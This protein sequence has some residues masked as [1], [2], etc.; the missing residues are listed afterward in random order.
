MDFLRRFNVGQRLRLLILIFAA[1]FAAYGYWSFR[2]LAEIKVGGPVFQRIAQSQNLVSDVLPPPVY[3]IESYLVA[4]RITAAVDSQ[5]QGQLID[6][7][8]TLHQQ[9][10]QR[11]AF[12]ANAQLK[13]EV[14]EVLLRQAHIPTLAF[15]DVLFQKFLPA[16]YVNDRSAMQSA[17]TSMTASYEAHRAAIDQVVLLAQA[18]ARDDE[19]AAYAQIQQATVLLFGI[20]VVAMALA[21]GL[22]TWIRRSIKRPLSQA[23]DIA[24]QVA[25]GNLSLPPSEPYDDEAGQLLI[26]L[27][28]MSDSLRETMDALSKAEALSRHDKQIA[29]TANQ[30]KSEFLANMSHE[31]RTPMNAVIGMTGLALRTELTPKQRGYLEKA[32]VAARNLMGIINDVLDFSKIEAGKLGF[33]Q[34]DFS[35]DHVLEHLASVTVLKAQE[36]GLELLFDVAKDV[37]PALVG[38]DMRLGQV[39]LNLVNN[40]VKFTPQGEIRVRVN[41]LERDTTTAL[42]RFEVQDTGIGITTAQRARL[43]EAFIQADASTTRQYGGTGLGLSIS[44]KLVEMMGGTIWVE[45]EEGKGSSFIFTASLRL[46]DMFTA[47]SVDADPLLQHLRILVVDDNQSAREIMVGIVESLNLEVQSAADGPSAIQALEAAQQ[48]GRPFHMVMM[49]WQMP[50]MDG[51]QAIRQIRGSEKIAETLATVMVT[52]FSRDDLIEKAE[53]VRLDG[54]LEKP[55][56][57]SAVLDTIARAMG[58]MRHSATQSHQNANNASLTAH[59]RGARVLLV[60]DNEVNQE[61]ASEILRESGVQVTV[62]GD[63][64]QA[65]EQLAKQPFDAVLMD[66]QMPVMDGFEATRRIRSDPG[67]ALLPILAMTANAMAGDREKCLAAGMNDHIAK[68]IEVDALLGTLARWVSQ[69]RASAPEVA[70]AAPSPSAKEAP[71]DLP[72]VD[73]ATALRRLRGNLS[74]YRNLLERFATEFARGDQPLQDALAAEDWTS[75]HRWAHTLKGLAAN[76]GAG[77]LQATAQA[78]ERGLQGEQPRE[79]LRLVEPATQALVRVLD[80]I[81]HER[82]TRR[83]QMQ[84]DTT[85]IP[86]P[87]AG[88]LDVVLL[89]GRLTELAQ[90]LDRSS[91]DAKELLQP[92]A[93]QLQGHAAVPGFM[94]IAQLVNDYALD[95]AL[96]ELRAWQLQWASQLG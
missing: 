43:F 84:A 85:H 32:N 54:L 1:G 81:A 35:L 58:H 73:T 47:L 30:S 78:L 7:V 42:L 83:A 71:P 4:L 79:A 10:L 51:V 37:P 2:T 14:A 53:G 34:R 72:G 94:Q 45:S 24:H 18:E 21:I 46:P 56:S 55:V 11:H 80:A 16:L 33:E 59:L 74:L 52:A 95:D 57:P 13:P 93:E 28:E 31:I 15:Y 8:K 91:S 29:E 87:V 96:A 65:L 49:D 26:A 92:I 62:A 6:R 88:P 23:V 89:Q 69:G 63:G 44:R 50:G 90:R 38:D 60:E 3:I 77:E 17:L 76:I 9:Y 70:S 64:V 61:L 22:A 36:K 40:A 86:V 41:C 68:P 25:A 67:F 19:A 75:A 20:L 82:A 66:W 12:W 27:K 48:Q 39:L 5:K